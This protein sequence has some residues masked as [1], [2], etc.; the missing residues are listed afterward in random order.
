MIK[1]YSLG[2]PSV[3]I[4]CDPAAEYPVYLFRDRRKEAAY[5]C[6]SLAEMLSFLTGKYPLKIDQ[7]G[8]SFLL[9]SGFV[10]TPSSIFSDLYIV[11][12]GD[13]IKL[14]TKNS[15]LS[16]SHGFQFPFEGVCG[17]GGSSYDEEKLLELL[18]DGV[19]TKVDS[20]KESY[21]FHSAGKDSN[22]IVI[23]LAAAGR[24]SEFTL[25]TQKS[26]GQS[27]ESAI[28]QKVAKKLG[29]RSLVLPEVSELSGGQAY[30]IERY[31]AKAPF[32]C[33]D[34]VSL[35]YPIYAHE[36]PELKAANIIDGMGN[37]VYLGHIPSKRELLLQN[38]SGLSTY[39]QC[40][41]AFVDSSNPLNYVLNTRAEVTGMSG[42]SYRDTKKLMPGST[43]VSKH[44]REVARKGNRDYIEFRG[45]TRGVY[46][47]KE[48]FTRK[49]ANFCDVYDSNLILPWC[50]Q[51]V[52][53]YA[54][55]LPESIRFDRKNLR[56]KV[57]LRE[58]LLD[59]LGI[60]SDAL[61][62]K[63]FMFSHRAIL[64]KD[65]AWVEASISSCEKW[66]KKGVQKVVKKLIIK[67]DSPIKIVRSRSELMLVRLLLLSLWLKSR[68]TPT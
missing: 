49:V 43:N 55:G 24:Q 59:R 52:V 17:N 48:M 5:Y 21:I 30:E 27:D 64:R 41:R 63:G 4:R 39:L 15:G 28:S 11:S 22:A 16:I 31:M 26:S 68:S 29:Y 12:I 7:S 65:I 18:A 10:P 14:E 54:A 62:K 66:D 8:L 60:D 58:L 47:D 33:C 34:P 38:L 56:N 19:L 50:D 25:V 67:L 32:P 36:F 3:N 1:K 46:Q 23:A 6:S 37:D 57:F 2:D 45:Q 20:S 53:D 42:I 51:A 40:L 61:G 9:Q 35:A 13:T 44:W